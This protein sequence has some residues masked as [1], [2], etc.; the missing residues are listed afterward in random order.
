MDRAMWIARK[1]YLCV[2]VRRVSGAF[3]GDD[4]E[5]LRGHCRELIEH[6]P[7]SSIEEAITCYEGIDLPFNRYV[8]MPFKEVQQ[9]YI[10]PFID[11]NG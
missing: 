5:F 7:D 6:Y 9:G 8:R 4:I 1:N 10:A 2:L 3:G 11:P